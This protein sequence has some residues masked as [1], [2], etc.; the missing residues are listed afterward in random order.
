MHGFNGETCVRVTSSRLFL[1]CKFWRTILVRST[2][3]EGGGRNPT[4]IHQALPRNVSSRVANELSSPATSLNSLL[5]I[6]PCRF[7]WT[8]NLEDTKEAV[9][10]RDGRIERLEAR[11]VAL[12]G[13]SQPQ[14]Q[15]V[16]P[17]EDVSTAAPTAS[18]AAGASALSGA[19]A[20]AA[21]GGVRLA[22]PV[23]PV[24]ST[25]RRVSPMMVGVESQQQQHASAAAVSSATPDASGLGGRV[26]DGNDGGEASLRNRLMARG[27]FHNNLPY[28]FLC[29]APG[30]H[31]S[32]L[33][34]RFRTGSVASMDRLLYN[35]SLCT[36][37]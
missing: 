33:W 10:E 26:G 30:G 9:K 20:L 35:I 12:T 29:S 3:N 13:E 8:Q 2:L 21:A 22:R 16:A 31:V 23:S 36:T 28:P 25:S 32:S 11:I 18:V 19:T 37:Q 5:N 17:M 15:G 34:G 6:S 7:A 4:T 14:S 1:V 27:E 24:P